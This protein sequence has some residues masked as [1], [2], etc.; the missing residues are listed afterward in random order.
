MRRRNPKKSVLFVAKY[1][2]V[3][4]FRL[5]DE[6]FVLVT[7]QEADSGKFEAVLKPL[8]NRRFK[9]QCL[10]RSGFLEKSW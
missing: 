8:P 7:N 6:T 10:L 5:N 9:L 3:V 1:S 4:P 2:G